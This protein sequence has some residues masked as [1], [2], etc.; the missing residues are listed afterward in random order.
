MIVKILLLVI[1]S[2][3]SSQAAKDKEET[4]RKNIFSSFVKNKSS[5]FN[6]INF[7]PHNAQDELAAK[8]LLPDISHL[9]QRDASEKV[10]K[11]IKDRNIINITLLCYAML[12]DCGA[13]STSSEESI[14]DCKWSLQITSIS[15]WIGRKLQS[16]VDEKEPDADDLEEKLDWLRTNDALDLLRLT[17]PS[18]LQSAEAHL[19]ATMTHIVRDTLQPAGQSPRALAVFLLGQLLN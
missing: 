5:G 11:Y 16:E 15:D 1:F 19:Q 14:R 6:T 12:E 2:A 8:R 13:D 17:A 9:T 18:L 3:L 4:P 10:R 7:K